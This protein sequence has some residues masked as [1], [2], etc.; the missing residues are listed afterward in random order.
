LAAESILTSGLSPLV[1]LSRDGRAASRDR[2]AAESQVLLGGGL[3][4]PQA[5][6]PAPTVN[7][8]A[9]H[10]FYLKTSTFFPSPGNEHHGCQ[11]HPHHTIHYLTPP[12]STTSKSDYF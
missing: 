10:G 2:P 8:D 7:T 4:L 3:Q 12:P 5:S 1:W 6:N 9:M 11:L